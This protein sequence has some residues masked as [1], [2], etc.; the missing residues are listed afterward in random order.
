MSGGIYDPGLLPEQ[1]SQ[2]FLRRC[3]RPGL[4][5]SAGHWGLEEDICIHGLHSGRVCTRSSW[6]VPLEHAQGYADD[7]Q[8]P[9]PTDIDVSVLCSQGW[10]MEV[11]CDGCGRC[12]LA[13]VVILLDKTVRKMGT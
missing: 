3:F 1:A 4:G 8:E 9:F 2:Y 6:C 12:L 11:L 5:N 10:Q 7:C 13:E